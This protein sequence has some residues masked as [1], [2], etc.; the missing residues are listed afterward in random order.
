MTVH[1]L[2]VQISYCNVYGTPVTQSQCGFVC[3]GRYIVGIGNLGNH[4]LPKLF[5]AFSAKM[6][7]IEQGRKIIS[8]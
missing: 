2:G 3:D 1:L 4:Y 8:F 7:Q 6:S 5:H